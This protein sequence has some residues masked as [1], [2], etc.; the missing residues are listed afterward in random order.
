[1][2]VVYGLAA[3]QDP[4]IYTKF[5]VTTQNGVGIVMLT[6]ELDYEHRTLYEVVVEARDRAGLGHG[7]GDGA[8]LGL[9]QVN[10]ARATVIVKVRHVHDSK[11]TQMSIPQL[12]SEHSTFSKLGNFTS[13]QCLVQNFQLQFD[14]I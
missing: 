1:M 8:S 14:S 5:A 13:I 9:G 11:Q 2:K 10:T 6:S 12:P 7:V 4:E 3:H